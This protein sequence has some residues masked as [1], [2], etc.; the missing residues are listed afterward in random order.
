MF[1]GLSNFKK[2]G[3]ETVIP[4]LATFEPHSSETMSHLH[5]QQKGIFF[6]IY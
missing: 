4:D 2:H 6:D 1:P 5:I 3:K